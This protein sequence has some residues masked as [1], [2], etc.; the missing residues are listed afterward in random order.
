MRQE[1]SFLTNA[2]LHNH[3]LQL[4]RF[5]MRS[6]RFDCAVAF[7]KRSGFSQIKKLL[8]TRL[9]SGMK[10]RFLVGLS[11]YQTE[12][13]VL[14]QLIKLR[15]TEGI[16]AYVSADEDRTTFHPKL[17]RFDDGKKVTVIVGSANLTNGGLIDNHETSAILRG[18]HRTDSTL[19]YL[20]SLIKNE[21]VVELT[22]ERLSDYRKKYDAYRALH[23]ISEREIRKSLA[24][25]ISGL[26]VLRIALRRMKRGGSMS[27]F[28]EQ[29]NLRQKSNRAARRILNSICRTPRLSREEFLLYY[30][31]LGGSLWHSGGLLRSK[32]RIAR[33][34][35][36]FRRIVL[37]ASDCASISVG[38]H[39]VSLTPA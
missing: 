25:A 2:T 26:D 32:T 10:A 19:K 37:A 24:T 27:E 16:E 34:P 11:F 18:D 38:L 17:Y 5:L 20:N 28:S 3:R 30:D 31:Q 14:E 13:E 12:P 15:E 21:D 39:P 33:T 29:I 22:R 23:R 35:E 4:R 9:Q 1:H 8:S 36:R 6:S 7:A